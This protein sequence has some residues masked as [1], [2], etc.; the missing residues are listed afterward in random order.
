MTLRF[1]LA[2][3]FSLLFL[4]CLAVTT[5]LPAQE[6][7]S[8]PETKSFPEVFEPT[9]ES[10]GK[11]NNQPEWL[12][13]AKLGIYFHWGPY[14]V[15]AFRTE[16]YP[17]FMHLKKPPRWGRGVQEYHKTTFGDPSEFGYHDFFPQFTCEKFDPAD[18]AELFE[19]AGAKFAG[20]VAQHHDGFS[21]WA[22]QANPNNAKQKGPKRDI[23]GDLFRELKKRD[24]KT[25]AT[26]H[27]SFTGQRE[28]G[29]QIGDRALSY[30][31]YKDDFF[32]SSDDPQLRKL[33][34]NL[35]ADEFNEYWLQ[36]VKEVVSEYSP[37]I[38]WFDSWLDVIPE[39]YV[40]RMAAYHYN[41]GAA[42]DQDVILAC[43]QQD[44]P[45]NTRILDIEQGGMKDLPEKVWMTDVTLSTNSWSYVQGQK[46]KPTELLVRNMVDV[47]SKR[48]VVL[49]NISPRADGVIIEEQRDRL[50]GLGKW[51]D[52]YGEAVY[53][54]R[55]HTMF[56]YGEAAIKDG[57]HGGQAATI[58][59]SASDIR[60]TRSVDGK[61]IYV[62]LLGQPEAGST[63]TIKHLDK[64][65]GD[66]FA[67]ESVTQMGTDAACD[68]DFTG[69][70]L[71]VPAPKPSEITEITTVFCVK[72]KN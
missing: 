39:E 57:S 31:P 28:R 66:D 12:Q 63:L 42:R 55:P 53:G 68:W 46:Y 50:R 58:K 52:I 49:L 26:F 38:I 43:K 59:Y 32:T 27:H 45:D 61:T 17:R 48:G 16:W 51:M 30:Y 37:D 11:T 69:G 18:W 29:G 9:W 6:T 62:F 36:L 8:A 40:Q 4:I 72:L 47:W 60:F 19:S 14:C 3:R 67:I 22:S 64:D 15:P 71:T 65:A 7:A 44:M 5:R 34:G 2:I 33:Y 70:V 21:M 24:L 1:N 41:A 10:L 23:L 56:G 54:T 35:P 13:D 20:P 25:I